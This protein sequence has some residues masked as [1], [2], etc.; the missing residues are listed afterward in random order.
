MLS[1]PSCFEECMSQQVCG[2]GHDQGTEGNAHSQFNRVQLR[3]SI[4]VV[5]QRHAILLYS[6]SHHV[7]FYSILFYWCVAAFTM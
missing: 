6:A 3:Y 1:I 7:I 5:Q 2:P 4:L